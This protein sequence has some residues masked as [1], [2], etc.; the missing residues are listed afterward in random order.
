MGGIRSS[1]KKARLCRTTGRVSIVRLQG[2]TGTISRWR[3]PAD[4]SANSLEH[5]LVT[6][7][8]NRLLPDGLDRLGYDGHWVPA[9]CCGSQQGPSDHYPQAALN[10]Q[11]I[12]G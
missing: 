5:D 7:P 3:L 8:L 9:D 10:H 12:S 1:E 6:M 2:E 4:N 11:A